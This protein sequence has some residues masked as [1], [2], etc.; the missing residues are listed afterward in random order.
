MAAESVQVL[1]DRIKL[2]EDQVREIRRL[3]EDIDY[4]KGSLPSLEA[5]I[6]EL[7][8]VSRGLES[9]KT[10]DNEQLVDLRKRLLGVDNNS[11]LVDAHARKQKRKS[12]INKINEIENNSNQFETHYSAIK[13]EISDCQE[14]VRIIS[15]EIK[16][17]SSQRDDLFDKI[18]NVRTSTTI[19]RT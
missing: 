8:N 1:K 18:L 5:K 13:E 14:R 2:Y 4:L 16:Q 12:I 7:T 6:N 10:I 11:N 19:K 17:L 15:N 3:T 9:F